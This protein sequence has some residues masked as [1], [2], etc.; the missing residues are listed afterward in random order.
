M[1]MKIIIKKLSEPD[2]VLSA[3]Y[4]LPLLILTILRGSYYYYPHFTTEDTEA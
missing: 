3:L 2:I 1:I 4:K